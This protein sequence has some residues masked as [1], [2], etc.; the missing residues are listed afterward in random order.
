MI[1]VSLRKGEEPLGP[2]MRPFTER[3]LRDA[4]F[5]EGKTFDG[6]WCLDCV[7]HANFRS[8]MFVIIE[9]RDIDMVDL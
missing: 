8:N 4:M 6:P 5:L 9:A 2:Q 1:G 3:S 7:G